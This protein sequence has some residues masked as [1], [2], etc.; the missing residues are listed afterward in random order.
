MNKIQKNYKQITRRWSWF[1]Y[2]KKIILK[3]QIKDVLTD[4]AK[5]HIGCGEKKLKGYINIDIVPTEGA[6]IVMDV[7]KNLFL[8]PLFLPLRKC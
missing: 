7:S 6:D 8:I 2:R 4:N 1:L 3:R 5:L